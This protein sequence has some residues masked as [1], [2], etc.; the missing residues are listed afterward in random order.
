MKLRFL[1]FNFLIQIE[2]ILTKIIIMENLTNTRYSE[3]DLQEFKR[4]ILAKME[5][6]KEDLAILKSSFRNDLGNGT[7]DTSPR[8]KGYDEGSETMSKESN[9]QLA[10]RQEKL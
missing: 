8:F 5:I 6:A 1:P 2:K 3:S 7:D 10:I 9:A 4:I